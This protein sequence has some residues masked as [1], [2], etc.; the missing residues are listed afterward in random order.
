MLWGSTLPVDRDE[1]GPWSEVKLDIIREYAAPYS[2]IVAGNGFHHL[3]IDGFAGPGSHL[4]RTTGEIV[5][6]S[7][8][9]ALAIEPPF[10]EYH[11]ID[12]NPA[13]VDQLRRYAANRADVYVH[14]G[15][16]NEILLR[17][18]FPR[19]R[20]N[21]RRRALCLLD[22]YN[23]D[24]SW[25]VVA[26]AGRMGS[27]EIF[28]NFMVMDMNMN[29]LLHDLEKADPVQVTRM[30]RFW[31][32]DSWRETAYEDDPQ[33]HLFDDAVKVKVGDANEKIAEAYRGRLLNVAGFKYAPR[34]LPF[35]NSLGA[36]IYYL[37]FASPNRTGKKIVEHIFGKHRI[38]QRL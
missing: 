21:D 16:C 24:L 22:P 38:S 5:P 4:S 19:A 6:G 13:R 37:F 14:P 10:A 17:D 12:A 26:T 35:V 30:N 31:G 8:L 7:P 3:Y 1:I 9:N 34:P 23:I 20:Y 25:E 33:H 18:V 2:K 15:D 28:L 11:F 29:V 27:I 36:T 32:G